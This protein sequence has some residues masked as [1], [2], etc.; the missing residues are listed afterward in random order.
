MEEETLIYEEESLEPIEIREY[1]TLE[2]ML[3]DNPRFL[4]FN[5]DELYTK[6]R[7]FIIN[8]NL[9]K[10]FIKLHKRVIYEDT[11]SEKYPKEIAYTLPK[12]DIFYDDFEDTYEYYDQRD[13]AYELSNFLL[14][15]QTL[16]ELSL[17]YLW[18]NNGDTTFKFIP[19]E[20][21]IFVLNNDI[22]NDQ[23]KLLSFDKIDNIDESDIISFI[24]ARWIIPKY[25]SENYLS[26]EYDVSN[27]KYKFVK[28]RRNGV[29]SGAAGATNYID[30]V[31]ANL[32]PSLEDVIQKS[33]KT[34]TD[35]HTIRSELEKYSYSLDNL[36]DEELGI[37]IE[38][39]ESI[40]ESSKTGESDGENDGEGDKKK[41]GKA[42]AAGELHITH[43]IK[44]KNINYW[45]TLKDNN[46][47][48]LTYKNEENRKQLEDRLTN[49]IS[50]LKNIE[51]YDHQEIIDP[52]HLARKVEINEL[53]MNDVIKIIK[54]M[55]LS[56]YEA[57]AEKL[58]INVTAFKVPDNEDIERERE[59]YAETEKSIIEQ[60]SGAFITRVADVADVKIGADTSK[61]DGSPFAVLNNIFE[62]TQNVFLKIDN[63]DDTIDAK[64]NADSIENNLEGSGG[65][66][67]GG[68]GSAEDVNAITDITEGV[69][70]ILVKLVHVL[71]KIRNVSG[72]PLDIIDLFN[73]I[74]VYIN[75]QS[76]VEQLRALLP[77]LPEIVAKRICSYTLVNAIEYIKDLANVKM[78]D[79]L[80][81]IYPPIYND[82]QK[83][84]RD[85]LNIALTVWWLNLLEASIN[86]QLNFS[87]LR[88]VIEHINIWS[89]YGQPVQE[90]A[91]QGILQYLSAV[92][93]DVINDS[94]GTG[95]DSDIGSSSG[96][97]ISVKTLRRDMSNV[98]TNLFQN[99]IESLKEK[100]ATTKRPKDKA[101][102]IRDMIADTVK[103]IKAKES[104]NVLTNFVESYIYLPTLLPNAIIKKLGTW[105]HGCCL[106]TI[107]NR[108]DADIDW[109]EELKPLW[110]LKELLAKDRWLTMTR[111]VWKTIYGYEKGVGVGEGKE[112][113]NEKAKKESREAVKID[114]FATLATERSDFQLVLNE[115]NDSWLSAT[116]I[117]SLTEDYDG[118]LYATEFLNTTMEKLYG[119]LSNKKKDA[120][121]K[122]IK[123]IRSETAILNV[124]AF[125]A[126]NLQKNIE[127]PAS[128]KEYTDIIKNIK[129]TLSNIK[130]I[131]HPVYIYALAIV[132]A[133]PGK[134]NNI[135][136]FIMPS[137]GN[138][139]S[140]IMERIKTAN[141]NYIIEYVKTQTMMTVN[142]IQ[143]YITKMREEEKNKKLQYQDEL[144]N[145]DRRL[146]KDLKRFGLKIE[147]P[148]G[149]GAGIGGVEGADGQGPAINGRELLRNED[150]RGE[151]DYMQQSQDY[152]RDDE[153]L[154]D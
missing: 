153:R 105:G 6:M 65:G 24:G 134:I 141:Y 132:L 14:R 32:V 4:A 91:D 130:N 28:W 103:A 114:F 97:T 82:W 90:T 131:E 30:W 144:S 27:K 119:N 107:G 52:Y 66:E 109:K 118:S 104:I 41:K 31:R 100:W 40:I 56:I 110:R 61:Y 98:A 39:I 19:K 18:E 34:V 89:P 154:D 17:P 9:T 75:R 60:K 147:L 67:G 96:A 115:S 33:I 139:T 143:S 113:E 108:Y 80:Q 101:K 5:D 44:L 142:E 111:P 58:Y 102:K 117:S 2:Q 72:L 37:L 74:K 78:S 7:E 138:I 81:K 59:L 68:S 57:L 1:V 13:R 77:E 11:L 140:T 120:I 45:D 123:E 62:E 71:V 50:N 15:Q 151:A 63:D 69:R 29:G 42:A 126:T 53:S 23:G 35:L 47:N 150:E 22:K 94:N 152:D 36:N 48:L 99:R 145:D 43:S 70:D 21:M 54:T 64:A 46:K 124:I 133:L 121:V 122:G 8:D 116:R 125:V 88:G 10:G 135:R 12:L 112:I 3:E 93:A 38:H 76:R 137:N 84:C 16:E 85:T 25:T 49:Y 83:V 129:E 79:E 148:A 149:V 128:L 20:G 55:R 73:E 106:V 127:N 136:S 92:A 51:K 146:L 86:K 26:E 87:I 95:T